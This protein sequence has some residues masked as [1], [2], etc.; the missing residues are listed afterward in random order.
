MQIL[1]LYYQPKVNCKTDKHTHISAFGFSCKTKKKS[2]NSTKMHYSVSSQFPR[3]N[4]KDVIIPCDTNCHLNSNL[5][6][7][8][9]E[10]IHVDS[11]YSR[12]WVSWW[13]NCKD[14]YYVKKYR[15]SHS[16]DWKA[17][18]LWWAYRYWF[19]LVFWILRVHERGTFA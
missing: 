3:Q 14:I 10:Y 12:S 11:I 15:V 5:F 16:K 8:F 18:R 1:L 2:L 17:I 6:S 4:A 19:F 7:F 13:S 9:Q